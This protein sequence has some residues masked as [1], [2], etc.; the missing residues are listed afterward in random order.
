MLCMGLSAL[1]LSLGALDARKQV[2][3]VMTKVFDVRIRFKDVSRIII[4]LFGKVLLKTVDNFIALTTGEKGYGSPLFKFHRV[5][6]DFMIQGGL[7]TAGDGTGGISI[8]AE[9]FSDENL[10][11][12]HYG[13]G[14]VSMANAGPDTSG[15]QFF[16]TLTKISWLDGKHMALWL[17]S[18]RSQV[19]CVLS[20]SLGV[21][22]H[23]P[24][25]HIIW[26]LH[27]QL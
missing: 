24:P 2:P 10:K 7:F 15:S 21:L 27:P 3:S 18:H 6:T 12:K 4:G 9:T 25:I 1:M 13:I 23:L 14:L 8:Y 26:K 22:A 11:L 20:V 5:I 17:S 16:I 19:E